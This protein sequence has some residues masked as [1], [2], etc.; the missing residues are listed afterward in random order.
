MGYIEDVSLKDVDLSEHA[1][2]LEVYDFLADEPVSVPR[3][4]HQRR[5]YGLERLL[6]EVLRREGLSPRL[7]FRPAGEQVDGSFVLDSRF[8]LLEAKWVSSA[9]EASQLYSFKGKVDGKLVGTIGIFLS[10]N[11]FSKDAVEALH[12]GKELSIILATGDDF[13]TALG[14]GR[15]FAEMVRAKLRAAAEDGLALLP[16]SA[17]QFSKSTMPGTLVPEPAYEEVVI[18]WAA[19]GVSSLPTARVLGPHRPTL[20]LVT[21]GERDILVLRELTARIAF[22]WQ[23]DTKVDFVR[24]GGGPTSTI[25]LSASINRL[26]R[27]QDMLAVVVDADGRA[28][29]VEA[30]LRSDLEQAAPGASLII[31][32]PELEQWIGLSVQDRR[33]WHRPEALVAAV[34]RLDLP[35]LEAR[36]KYFRELVRLLTVLDKLRRQS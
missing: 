18:D 9:I 10:I 29:A 12:R 16:L 25:K 5:G 19:P 7:S 28:E 34:N 2:L 1:D 14:P 36:D 26:L 23:L 27:E 32:E 3:G 33:L 17:S 30:T 24:A 20:F 35:A 8:I 6:A 21:E 22:K 4:W 31:L 15:G 13:R 11:G